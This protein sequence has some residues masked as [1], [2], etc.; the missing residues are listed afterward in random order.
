MKRSAAVSPTALPIAKIRPV[1]IPGIAAGTTT[2]VTVCHLVAPSAKLDSLKDSG[3]DL[4]ASSEARIIVG[5]IMK[6]TVSVPESK[7][8]PISKYITKSIKPNSPKMIDGIPANVSVPNLRIS[9][10]RL[11]RAYSVK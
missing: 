11:C 5:R 10:K 1:I 4:M 3:T 9:L 2:R 7:P 8:T 6:V